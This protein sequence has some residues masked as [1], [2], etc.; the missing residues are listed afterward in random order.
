MVPL[1]REKMI[2]AKQTMPVDQTASLE[3][4]R[5]L[6][7]LDEDR[8]KA[9]EKYEQIRQ[10]LIDYFRRRGALDPLALADDVIERVTR[11]VTEIAK[12]FVGTPSYYFL[13]VARRVIAEYW[14]RPPEQDLPDNLPF[15]SSPEAAER[16]ELYFKSLERCWTRLSAKDQ[17]F[18]LRYCVDSPPVKLSTAREQLAE[19]MGATI[20][21]LRVMAHRLKRRL[22][23]CI[24]GL[25]K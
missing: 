12:D 25:M 14:R 3:F 16:R 18:L 10:N 5:L 7:W 24:E 13:A 9:G 19:E 17:R 6:S 15:F 11:R 8:N 4:E 20:N 23:L 22:R 1:R 21:M 2:E